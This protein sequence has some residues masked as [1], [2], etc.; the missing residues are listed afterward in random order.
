[1]T[2][3][4]E[5]W[6]SVISIEARYALLDIHVRCKA[7]GERGPDVSYRK[8]CHVVLDTEK[9][10]IVGESYGTSWFRPIGIL[11]VDGQPLILVEK[12]R[13]WV[14][15]R[16]DGSEAVPYAWDCPEGKCMGS[17]SYQARLIDRG[18]FPEG[19]LRVAIIRSGEPFLLSIYDLN[20]APEGHKK[21][22]V[23]TVERLV[24][25]EDWTQAWL[26]ATKL[27]EEMRRI[28]LGRS[29]LQKLRDLA[30]DLLPGFDLEAELKKTLLYQIEG[31]PR[32]MRMFYQP[33]QGFFLATQRPLTLTY[34]D[35]RSRSFRVLPPRGVGPLQP[36]SFVSSLTLMELFPGG[37]DTAWGFVHGAVLETETQYNLR[38]PHT[39]PCPWRETLPNGQVSCLS[40][41]DLIVRIP[42]DTLDM[43]EW[44]ILREDD[45]HA[46]H[47]ILR[48][49][50]VDNDA[51]EYLE[52][53]PGKR[54]SSASIVV[55]RKFFR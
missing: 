25:R 4:C 42:L 35:S 16:P 19:P 5:L 22:T 51:V 39:Q 30:L 36:I 27:E 44:W 3:T 38:H 17:M 29:V 34:V 53:T 15:I 40:F 21:G 23:K 41:V 18:V 33:E 50:R 24:P 54:A 48:V 14:L 9:Y 52:T 10:T 28:Y 37:R 11:E 43:A 26:Q 7:S 32:Q 20:P 46:E 45:G 8:G 13:Q 47:K 6:P 2:S 12:I 1:M 49:L 31:A 55:K